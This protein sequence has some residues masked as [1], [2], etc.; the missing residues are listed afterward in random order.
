MITYEVGTC[1]ITLH[2][3]KRECPVIV[4]WS[5]TQRLRGASTTFGD[6]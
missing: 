6:R 2:N 5:A 1:V 4:R 3:N